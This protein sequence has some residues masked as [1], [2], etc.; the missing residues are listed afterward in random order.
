MT[1]PG[2]SLSF[3]GISETVLLALVVAASYPVG[4]GLNFLARFVK[5]ANQRC[6]IDLANDQEYEHIKKAVE[7]FFHIG[8]T[9]DSWRYCYGIVVKHGYSVNVD[10]FGRLDI[11]CRSIM[12]SGAI[13]FLVATALKLVGQFAWTTNTLWSV[14]LASAAI[15]MTFLFSARAYSRAF[16]SAIYEA[17]Y[18]WYVDT[19]LP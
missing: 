3:Y 14:L 1:F 5:P 8:A 15:F 9:P 13:V 19:K 4:V 18:S 11:F 17:F 10:L 16:V 6:A 2:R 7:A 12:T